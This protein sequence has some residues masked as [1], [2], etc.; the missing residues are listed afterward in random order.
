MFVWDSTRSSGELTP[1][2]AE[3]DVFG[4]F[5]VFVDVH[6]LLY[7]FKMNSVDTSLEV[8]TEKSRITFFNL[9]F[10]SLKLYFQAAI[11]N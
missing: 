5:K 2:G 8:V 9:P 11:G 7:P 3:L 4:H 10:V 6:L 1:R